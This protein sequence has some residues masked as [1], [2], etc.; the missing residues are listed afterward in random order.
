MA[1]LLRG[2]AAFLALLV[3]V[4]GGAA[5]V[6][7]RAADW[8]AAADAPAKADAIIVLGAE[9]TRAITAA[10]LYQ[11]GLARIVYL[12]VPVRLPRHVEL[13][14]EGICWPWFEEA[15]AV[16]LRN[17]GVPDDA[18]QLLGNDLLSTVAEARV[19]ARVL[20]PQLRTL[21][22]VTSP[23]HVYRTR[24]IFS[25]HLP[26]TRVLVVASAAEPLPQRWWTDREAAVHVSLEFAKLIFYRLGFSFG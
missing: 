22:V 18:I 25:E 26:G 19:T 8:L 15:A 20:G 23:Y 10:E 12:T 14:K 21:L 4:A 2:A 17:R 1:C 5:F 9:P 6:A 24:L 3:A 16:L 11:R 13:E 7:Y